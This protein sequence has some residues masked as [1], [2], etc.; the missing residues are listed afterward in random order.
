MTYLVLRPKILQTQKLDLKVI[1]ENEF[2]LGLRTQ[3][4]GEIQELEEKIGASTKRFYE[5][6]RSEEESVQK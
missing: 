4:K 5:L 3:L 6:T 1:K 2:N